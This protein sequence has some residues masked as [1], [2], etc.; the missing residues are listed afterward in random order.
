MIYAG[1]TDASSIMSS[2]PFT[3]VV[4]PEKQLFYMHSALVASLSIQLDRTDDC[5]VEA[6]LAFSEFAYTE[7]YSVPEFND[8]GTLNGGSEDG[9]D[10]TPERRRTK[11]YLLRLLIFHSKICSFADR[12]FMDDLQDFGM[13]R[14]R[15]ALHDVV[16][17][18]EGAGV[19]VQFLTET[20]AEAPK[21]VKW[22]IDTYLGSRVGRLWDN[23]D[24]R[25]FVKEKSPLA[26]LEYKPRSG[27][28]S[29]DK[30][31]RRR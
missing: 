17:N 24:F 18:S 5:D 12:H 23:E 29:Q 1:N 15:N 13:A 11:E 21:K 14:L 28:S 27:K 7:K 20:Y 19:I 10:V 6:F 31:E 9:A 30:E 26:S 4:G 2:D 3:F 25:S 16:L 8:I 22:V